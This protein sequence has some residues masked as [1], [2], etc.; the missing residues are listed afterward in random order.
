MRERILVVSPNNS[1]FVRQD[2]EILSRDFEVF[3][4]VFGSRKGMMMLVFQAKL[5]FWLVW[6]LPK[7]KGVFIWFADYHS[8][9]PIF[10][11]KILGK[12]SFQVI[13][14]FDAAKL[15][16]YNYGGHNKSIR[17]WIISISCRNATK[18]LAVSHFVLRELQKQTN[19]DYLDKAT[20]IHNGIDLNIFDLQP[21]YDTTA[22]EGVICVSLAETQMRIKIKGLDLFAEVARRTPDIKFSLIGVSGEAKQSLEKLEIRNLKLV[23]PI[24]RSELLSYFNVSKLVCQFS[25]FESFGMALAEGML[26]G[27]IPISIRDI[28][29]SEVVFPPIGFLSQSHDIDELV[30]LVRLGLNANNGA[31]ARQLIL[32]NFGLEKRHQALIAVINNS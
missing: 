14:G 15:P 19:E 6:N 18:I 11:S 23:E 1:S 31:E 5:F 21:E 16:E 8:L 17:H 7:S 4:F 28:G 9:L 20:V 2:V 22:R 12:K 13:G 27:C 26:C 30:S 29:P 32:D 25:R 10:L 3:Q 24:K